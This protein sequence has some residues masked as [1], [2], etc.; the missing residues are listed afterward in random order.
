MDIKHSTIASPSFP[1]ILRLYFILLRVITALLCLQVCGDTFW[2]EIFCFYLQSSNCY[3][4]RVISQNVTFIFPH[5]LLMSIHLQHRTK[6]RQNWR[7]F[8]PTHCTSHLWL[9]KYGFRN[10]CT[11]KVQCFPGWTSISVFKMPHTTAKQKC[12]CSGHLGGSVGK[13]PTS[14]QMIS[15]FVGL[16]PILGSVLTAQSLELLRILCLPL[17]SAPPP[18]TLCLSLKINKH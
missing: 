3:Y 4:L 5:F 13:R 1:Q 10:F 6:G 11:M 17:L 15:R 18:L 14:A 8:L 9:Q 2:G 16:S 12:L 7:V